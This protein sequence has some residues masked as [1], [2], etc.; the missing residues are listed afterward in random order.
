MWWNVVSFIK[1]IYR[2]FIISFYDFAEVIKF[3]RSILF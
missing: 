2:A 3:E 1:Q